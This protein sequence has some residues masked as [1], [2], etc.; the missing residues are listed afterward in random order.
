MGDFAPYRVS[1]WISTRTL[2]MAVVF[3]LFQ[4]ML[5]SRQSQLV[6]TTN[7]V[8]VGGLLSR[9]LPLPVRIS[10]VNSR[11]DRLYAS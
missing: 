1:V 8:V 10:G 7:Q 6:A 11:I 2:L 4:V 9:N 5:L 3:V